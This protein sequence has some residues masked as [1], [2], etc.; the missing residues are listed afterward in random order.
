MKGLEDQAIGFGIY[1]TGKDRLGKVV[2]EDL[3]TGVW[4]NRRLLCMG[5]RER[6]T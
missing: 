3:W 4:H 5:S 6:E 2:T 1:S